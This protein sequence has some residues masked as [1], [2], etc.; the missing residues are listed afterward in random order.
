L[1]VTAEGIETAGQ[2]AALQEIGCDLGQGFY[3]ARP[4]PGEIVRALVHHRLHWRR[5]VSA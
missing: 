5:R 4:Q 2:L 1:S 3:F